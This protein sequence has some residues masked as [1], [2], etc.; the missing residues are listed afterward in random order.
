MAEPSG[1]THWNARGH[2]HGAQSVHKGVRYVLGALPENERRNEC[3]AR[4][5]CPLEPCHSVA[6]MQA[7]A[8]H[9]QLEMQQVKAV[10]KVAVYPL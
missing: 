7:G 10:Q 9:I 2:Q 5:E 3:G 8:N 6:A 1:G 4:V